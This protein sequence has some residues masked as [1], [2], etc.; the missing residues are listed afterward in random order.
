[1]ATDK[2]GRHIPRSFCSCGASPRGNGAHAARRKMH[3]AR[4]DGHRQVTR[5]VYDKILADPALRGDCDCGAGDQTGIGH[6][7]QPPCP[8]YARY[9]AT[10]HRGTESA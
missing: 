7:S 6:R 9:R 4:G 5:D 1:M 3:K 2:H 10:D 8:A